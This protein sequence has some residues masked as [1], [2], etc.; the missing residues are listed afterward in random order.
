MSRILLVNADDLGLSKEVNDGIFDALSNGIVR[1]LS[2]FSMP[3][4]E[5]DSKLFLRAGARLGIHLSLSFG[6]S[7]SS[8]KRISSLA[9][10][11]GS[12][13]TPLPEDIKYEDIVGELCAQIRFFECKNGFLPV[14]MNFHKHQN[15]SN[16]L[17]MSAAISVAKSF[18]IPMRSASS[19]ARILLQSACVPTNDHFLG[20]VS[21][22]PFWTEE[23]LADEIS[24]LK[25]GITELMCHPGRGVKEIPGLWYLQQRN[26]ETDAL[27]SGKVKAELRHQ[28]DG[29]L[30]EDRDI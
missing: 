26:G 18:S 9:E 23:R 29:G 17:L 15:E 12:F 1:H 27:V 10:A 5:Y 11:D 8:P 25:D 30:R 16:P 22:A 2:A 19:Q 7:V 14:H 6:K 13:R 24:N 21:E 4:F 20:G 28:I 3:D